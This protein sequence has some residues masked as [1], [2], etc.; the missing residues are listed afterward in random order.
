MAGVKQLKAWYERAKSKRLPWE[1]G[2]QDCYDYA[3]PSRASFFARS[4]G[5]DAPEIFDETAVIAVPE[6]ASR[7]QAGLIPNYARWANLEGGSETD[8]E[9]LGEVNK[10]LEQV[11]DYVFEIVNSSNFSDEASECLLDLAVGTAAMEIWDGNAVQPV[12]YTA[13]PLPEL[14]IDDGPDGGIDRY[15]RT[16][17]LRVSQLERKWPKGNLPEDVRQA[18]AKDSK[19][20]EDPMVTVVLCVYR[21]H[22][23]PNQ[24]AWHFAVFLPAHDHVVWTQ[25]LKGTGSGPYIGFRW[26]KAAGEVWGRGPLFNLMPAVRT[27][28][29]TVQMILENAEMAIAGMYTAE[30][31]GV[32]NVDNIR[33]APGTIIPTAPG[34]RGLQPVSPA[35]RFD[36]SQLVLD[37]M[38]A[39]IRK[40][41]YNET[42]GSPDTTPM[43]ATEVA[44]RMADLS[45]QIGSA[46]GRLQVE[47]VNK[48]IA[49]TIY[50]LKAQG[51][52]ELP[53]VNGREVKIVSSSPLAQAQAVE[54]INAVNNYLQ[55]ML[56][57]FGPEEL[58]MQV[59]TDQTAIYLRD[60]FG[61]PERLTRT[62]EEKRQLLE[63]AQAAMAAQAGMM[64]EDDEG[65]A[66]LPSG[67]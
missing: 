57:F 26:A 17:R 62:K 38:R 8:P 50:I 49:R 25:H 14:H 55:T 24:E 37:E 12:N 63:Q 54:D 22:D 45:R 40:G 19:D 27:A 9:E 21:D 39:N 31:D 16:R 52:I 48:V 66:G 28:N 42:L 2:Y 44:Q 6:F 53:T 32:I 59:N 13:V 36:V 61:V 41:L 34:S 11:T 56:Q 33:I 4:P 64:G 18:I 58:K 23:N 47:F 30:D 3:M 5:S 67:A 1:A 65:P 10:Q 46:F 51:R 35:G 43:S 15:F 60:K 20:D 7:I 29:L